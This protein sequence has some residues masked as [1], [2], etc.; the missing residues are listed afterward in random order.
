MAW[1]DK[2]TEKAYDKARYASNREAVKARVRAYA[3]VNKQKI[4]T[5]NKNYRHKNAPKLKARSKAYYQA[6]REE[7]IAYQQKLHST[8]VPVVKAYKKI[9]WAKNSEKFS[10]E[11]K[12][13]ENAARRRERAKIWYDET[14]YAKHREKFLARNAKRRALKAATQVEDIDFRQILL[15]SNGVCGICGEPF[16][17]FGIDFDHIIPLARGGTHTK[18]NIQATHS[19]CNRAKGAKVG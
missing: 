7:R 13:P 17:L 12:R 11:R 6:H 10:Q 16:D 15:K 14:Y 4:N 2:A 8:K 3:S 19:R 5:R 18:E 9:W 1:K